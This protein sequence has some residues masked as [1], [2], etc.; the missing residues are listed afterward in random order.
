MTVLRDA[1]RPKIERFALSIR[2]RTLERL[3]GLLCRDE[4]DRL[5]RPVL[6]EMLRYF[7]GE[8]NWVESLETALRLL[9]LS[10]RTGS[11]D[12]GQ[13]LNKYLDHQ[14]ADIDTL[15]GRATRL[16]HRDR[17]ITRR[18]AWVWLRN[19]LHIRRMEAVCKAIRNPLTDGNLWRGF[20]IIYRT[21]H[22]ATRSL[23]RH[24]R[25]LAAADLRS[26][27]REDDS[28][29]RNLYDD[30]PRDISFG[31]DDGSLRDRLALIDS[32]VRRS[33]ADPWRIPAERLFL[34]TRPPTYFDVARRL[35]H[36]AA[37]GPIEDGLFSGLLA[38][39]NSIRGTQYSEPI[40]DPVDGHTVRLRGVITSPEDEIDPQLIL[41]N[42]VVKEDWL[43]RTMDGNAALVVERIEGLNDLIGAARRHAKKSNGNSLLILP[44]LALPRQWMRYLA[45]HVATLDEF[46][47]IVGLEYKIDRK[48]V[49]NEAWSIL[50]G[51]WRTVMPWSWEKGFPARE[52]ERELNN[53]GLTFPLHRSR[54]G[55]D[56][57][58]LDTSYGRFSVLICSELMEAR[59]M[60]SLLRKIEI[61]VVPAWNKDTASYDH[62]V[63]SVGLQLHSIVAI[64]NNGYYSDCR[65]WAPR[66][67]R[68][69]RD[70]CRL[71]ER[72]I[73]DVVSVAIPLRSL[74]NFRMLDTAR[75]PVPVRCVR[76]RSWRL[77][78][79][80]W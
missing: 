62:L 5:A 20:E 22:L 63:Q 51:G 4:A 28:F 35:L 18:S 13:A 76:Q 79:P 78:P 23:S 72:N 30:P 53:R 1:D 6:D 21:R 44:E 39:V 47:I 40:A 14:F 12:R 37:S 71:I 57:V 67:V 61:L 46:G 31:S 32:F 69:Q 68:W 42:L 29:G 45:N 33:D 7:E 64:A 50:P 43:H 19:F 49:Y 59:H 36:S 10:L 66:S 56:K 3:S 25:L 24:A 48:I 77:L 2:L 27:D 8:D 60:S 34:C 58:V 80:G 52:E 75:R 41:G 73:N 11:R 38:L 15:R 9:Q 26:S 74:R 55:L 54:A 17:E 70:L 16:F 65:V